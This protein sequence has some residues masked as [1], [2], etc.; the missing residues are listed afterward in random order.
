[1]ELS[2][3]ERQRRS[4]LA[5]RL[6]SEGKLGGPKSKENAG[7]PRVK[8]ASELVAEGI[9][10]DAPK[11]LKA[12]R[13]ALAA[14]SPS[15]KLK[16]ALEMLNIERE[17]TKIQLK[18]EKQAYENMDRD[19]LLGLIGERFK[20][21]KKEGVDVEQLIFG[22]AKAIDVNAKQIENGSE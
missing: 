18:E 6:R 19:K 4:D 5:K 21:L 2:V 17:E 20:Q 7:R 8:R 11:I 14:D 22:K 1:M 16:A 9:R 15:V 3:E 12:L 10:E 13:M